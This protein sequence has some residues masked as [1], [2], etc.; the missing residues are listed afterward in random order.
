MNAPRYELARRV[1]PS[2]LV[3]W[4]VYGGYKI[5]F[6]RWVRD[7]ERGWDQEWQPLGDRVYAT[8]G[9]ALAAIAVVRAQAH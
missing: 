6:S 5:G 8:E 4:P 7:P 2:E 1:T 9:E 3:P